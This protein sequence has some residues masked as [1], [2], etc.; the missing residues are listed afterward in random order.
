MLCFFS[1]PTPQSRALPACPADGRQ[2]L[3]SS[4]RRHPFGAVR[5]APGDLGLA[6]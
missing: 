3:L 2:A 4:C 1:E 6:A 5:S